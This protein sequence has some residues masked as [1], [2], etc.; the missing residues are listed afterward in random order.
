M[1]LPYFILCVV[2]LLRHHNLIVVCINPFAAGNVYI[3]FESSIFT[4]L[5]DEERIYTFKLSRTPDEAGNVK[6]SSM[7]KNVYIRL[8]AHKPMTK[9]KIENKQLPPRER[10]IHTLMN[11]NYMTNNI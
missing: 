2:R 1:V 10:T 4:C 7:T 8:A 9:A 6:H 5:S 3:R 11:H